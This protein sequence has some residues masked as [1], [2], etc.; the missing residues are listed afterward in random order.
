MS[1]DQRS[2][3]SVAAAARSSLPTHKSI[4]EVATG[5][6]ERLV[7]K[8]ADLLIGEYKLQKGVK[9]G[10]MFLQVE[11]ESMQAGLEKISEMPSGHLDEQDRIWARHVRELSYDI[12]D[13]IDTLMVRSSRHNEPI[14]AHGLNTFV[15]RCCDILAQFRTRR[16]IATEIRS[17]KRCVL[18]VCE[19]RHRYKID[20]AVVKPVTVSID[21]RLFAQY[22]Q[23][24][25]LVGIEEARDDLIKI[26]MEGNGDVFM[27]CA[28]TVSIVGFGGLGKTTL[29]RA[30]Y[31][32]IGAQFDCRVFVS[33][34]QTPDV[35]KLFK[36]M[37]YELG[38]I[39]NNDEILGEQW[40]ISELRKFLQEKRY[41]RIT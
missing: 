23:A 5:A 38:N 24:T 17:I 28:K 11:L 16:N 18:E 40:L 34:S 35:M 36:S 7:P 41:A 3:H 1:A 6:L 15:R 10:I 19:R 33:V 27:P 12:E 21:P 26:L 22:K 2:C 32:K 39:V 13:C 37:L 8:L 31:E 20:S 30:V 25:E 4:M 29:A 9:G 14:R